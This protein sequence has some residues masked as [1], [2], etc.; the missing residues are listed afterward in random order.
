MIPIGVEQTAVSSKKILKSRIWNAVYGD[1]EKVVD[2]M[3]KV[4]IH[5]TDGP[6][7]TAFLELYEKLHCMLSCE[8]HLSGG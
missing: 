4:M 7:K 8:E 1:V 5:S 3:A 6:S 2:E